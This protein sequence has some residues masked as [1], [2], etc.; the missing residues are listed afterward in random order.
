MRIEGAALCNVP[1]AR[2]WFI[3]RISYK[4]FFYGPKNSK[5]VSAW[6]F[7]NRWPIFYCTFS[8]CCIT[9]IVWL[10]SCLLYFLTGRY[11]LTV[12]SVE[13][14]A[15][16]AV[17]GIFVL[18]RPIVCLSTKTNG[19]F[20]HMHNKNALHTLLHNQLNFRDME[21][22]FLGIRYTSDKNLLLDCSTMG[23]MLLLLLVLLMVVFLLLLFVLLLVLLL[24]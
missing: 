6:N 1:E 13:K 2:Q 9:T 20:Y 14:N 18:H 24:S 23:V 4:C 19:N 17:A 10:K 16:A 11:L 7:T 15:L 3:Y 12:I 8:S 21:N 22:V 5:P